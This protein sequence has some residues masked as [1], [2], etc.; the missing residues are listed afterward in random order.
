ML[1]YTPSSK[2]KHVV[3]NYLFY[4]MIR[5]RKFAEP[6]KC[7]DLFYAVLRLLFSCKQKDDALHVPVRHCSH[8]RAAWTVP[9]NKTNGIP[10]L[11]EVVTLVQDRIFLSP[12]A[13]WPFTDH[14]VGRGHNTHYQENNYFSRRQHLSTG[15]EI[16]AS[17]NP[18][19]GS[20][21][22]SEESTH[23]HLT[24]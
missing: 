17:S 18:R 14:L 19:T 10:L 15:K 5:R 23:R 20:A 22:Y 21:I 7:P 12:G 6:M 16:R 3:D 4:L 1:L 24:F 13:Y 2:K 11:Y 9:G 8:R